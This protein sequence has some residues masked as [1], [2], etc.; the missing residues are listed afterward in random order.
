MIL[1]QT[2]V[3]RFLVL[4]KAPSSNQL[5]VVIALCQTH[6]TPPAFIYG[7]S[8]AWRLFEL[9]SYHH[10]NLES[11][12]PFPSSCSL[13]CEQ[14]PSLSLCTFDHCSISRLN[15]DSNIYQLIAPSRRVVF[16]KIGYP[17][18]KGKTK[19]NSQEEPLSQ[20]CLPVLPLPQQR[21]ALAK[22]SQPR[23]ERVS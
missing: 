14:T 17:P 4:P 12:C 1:K 19:S 6:L 16:S 11:Y 10:K 15:H 2:P 5:G 18:R 7:S 8:L 21:P 20:R 9:S 22:H 23:Q 3:Q 13:L